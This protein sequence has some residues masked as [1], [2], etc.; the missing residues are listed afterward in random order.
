MHLRRYF[1]TQTKNAIQN[2]NPVTLNTVKLPFEVIRAGRKTELKLEYAS[3]LG[4]DGN[5]KAF[6]GTLGKKTPQS[7]ET[8]AMSARVFTVKTSGRQC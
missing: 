4:N 8:R 5:T 7:E 3:V 2:Y 1:K 6:H